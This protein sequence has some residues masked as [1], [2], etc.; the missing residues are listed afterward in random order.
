MTKSERLAAIRALVG[1]VDQT[2]L[3]TLQ[4]D[5]RERLNP[6]RQ[7]REVRTLAAGVAAIEAREQI[8]L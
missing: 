3:A 5:V 6:R 2:D 1:E 8:G 7:W 4:A